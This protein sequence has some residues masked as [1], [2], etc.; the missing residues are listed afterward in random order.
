MKSVINSVMQQATMVDYP[1]RLSGLMFTSGCNFHCGF[2]HNAALL[3]GEADA[4]TYDYEKLDEILKG[5]KR[6]W[7]NAITITGG[8]P[9]IHEKLPETLEFIKK[10]GFLIKLDSNGSNPDMLR[11]CLPFLDYIAMDIKC[12]LERYEELVGFADT[13]KISESIN[14]I[15]NCGKQYEFRTTMVETYFFEEDIHT[16]GKMVLGAN[17]YV[18]QPFIPHEDLPSP[19]LRKL[20]RTRPSFLHNAAEILRAYVKKAVV[21]GEQAV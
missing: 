2:C 11:R 1:G 20:H 9:T 18:V 4:E 3:H 15:M 10:R 13:D 21:R 17:L 19:A 14:L 5:F 8:E 6:Q 16:C 7:T 12:P